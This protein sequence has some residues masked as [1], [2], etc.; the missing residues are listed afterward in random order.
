MR[1]MAMHSY[2]QPWRKF[3]VMSRRSTE[4][5]HLRSVNDLLPWESVVFVVDVVWVP[6]GAVRKVVEP[7]FCQ[8]LFDNRR[9]LQLQR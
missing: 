8:D 7:V 6:S 2:G 5:K 9:K 3:K 4:K 1:A